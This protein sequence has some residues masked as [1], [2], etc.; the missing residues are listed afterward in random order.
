MTRD[1]PKAELHCHIEGAAPTQLARSQALKYGV[2]INH[3]IDGERF[4]WQDFTSFLTAYDAVAA[5]FRTEEDYALLAEQYLSSIARQGAIYS[6]VFTSPDHARNA[7]LSP[8]AYLNGLGEG[9]RRAKEKHDIEGR[10]IITCV[11]HFGPETAIDVARFAAS[12]PHPLVTGFGM[13]GDERMGSHKD[14]APAFDI[15]RAAGLGITTHAGEVVGAESVTDAL[16]HVHPT[17]IGHGVRAIE[18]PAVMQRLVDE[19]VVL[20]VC[21]GSNISLSVYDKM[22]DHPFAALKNAGVKVTI[23]SD[24]PPFFATNLGEE[25]QTVHSVFGLSEAELRHTTRTALECAFVD[26]ETRAAL[27]AKL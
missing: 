22:K 13:G 16:D 2:D 24:D 6:E 23:N 11:R 27:I 10:I 18:D 1:V 7:G 26:E 14:F 25:Y 20:E 12:I 15:A 8:Q 19:G 4:V 17:R 9:M 21:P 5:L 3:L